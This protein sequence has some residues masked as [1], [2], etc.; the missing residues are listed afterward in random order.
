MGLSC[1]SLLH[2]LPLL[3]F[4]PLDP[5]PLASAPFNAVPLAAGPLSLLGLSHCW[6]S[7]AVALI[8]LRLSCCWANRYISLAAAYLSVFLSLLVLS[9][10]WASLAAELSRRIS[11]P[12]MP[13]AVP[14]TGY[15]MLCWDALIQAL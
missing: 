9:R 6:T 11:L 13:L 10:C 2:L 15:L 4:S 5:T 12:A 14:L 1:L 3:H 8:P 7:L